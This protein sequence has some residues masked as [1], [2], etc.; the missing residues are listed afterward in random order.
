MLISL[1]AWML[2]TYL[3]REKHRFTI[4]FLPA[5]SSLQAF[6]V[7]H[8]S[9]GD[10]AVGSPAADPASVYPPGRLAK[11]SRRQMA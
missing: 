9:A 11:A 5:A 4:N 6:S 8:W 7:S 10:P 3:L 2:D 1:C